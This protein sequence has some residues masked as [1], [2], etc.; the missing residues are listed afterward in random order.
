MKFERVRCL[1]KWLYFFKLL[2]NRLPTSSDVG[3]VMCVGRRNQIVTSL[4]RARMH[5][6]FGMRCLGY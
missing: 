1:L 3:C 6:L 5:Q 4:C 2:Q